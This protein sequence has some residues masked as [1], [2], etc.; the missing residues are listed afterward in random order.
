MSRDTIHRVQSPAD[1]EVLVGPA[2]GEIIEALRLLGPCSVAEVAEAIDRP[3]D[4]LYRH[5]EILRQHGF[6]RDA[7][8]RKGGRNVE[9]LVD[10]VAD[11]FVVDFQDNLGEGENRAI[12]KTAD[13]FL[14]GM[15][16]VVRDS[17]AARQLDFSDSG[18]NLSMNCELAWLTPEQLQEVRQLV[19]RFKQ[20]MDEGKKQR[21]GRLYMSLAMAVPVTRKRGAKRKTTGKRRSGGEELTAKQTIETNS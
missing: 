6:V 14:R 13:S 21:Q 20:L 16:R 7:G 12:I 5:L 8:F 19:R 3:A 2:R 15:A 4:A 18:R 1:W 10:V 9:L 17:A 11:D